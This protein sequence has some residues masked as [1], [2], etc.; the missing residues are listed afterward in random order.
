MRESCRVLTSKRTGIASLLSQSV[1]AIAFADL[2]LRN[3]Q[4]FGVFFPFGPGRKVLEVLV[5][6]QLRM[7]QIS[8]SDGSIFSGDVWLEFIKSDKRTLPKG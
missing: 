6:V 5:Q 7:V 4:A 8:E 3:V 1:A 2:P